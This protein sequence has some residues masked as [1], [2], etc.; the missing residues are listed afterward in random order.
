MSNERDE[1]IEIPDFKGNVYYSNG[2]M[3]IKIRN[4]FYLYGIIEQTEQLKA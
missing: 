4:K 3:W 2:F 1:G